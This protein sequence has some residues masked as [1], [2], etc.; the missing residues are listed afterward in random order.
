MMRRRTPGRPD[1]LFLEQLVESAPDAM[2]VVDDAGTV[3]FANR[4]CEV[5]TATPRAQLIGRSVDTLV[6][7]GSR[8]AH[9]AN[10]DR[11]AA[12][13]RTRPMGAGLDLRLR[14]AAGVEVPVDISLSPFQHD[15]RR[16]VA[17]AIRDVT[18][19]EHAEHELRAA[20]VELQ[21]TVEDLRRSTELLLMANEL[22]DL[23]HSC[24]SVGDAYLVLSRFGASFFPGSSGALYRSGADGEEL[25]LARAW[26]DGTAFDRAFAAAECWG[27]RRS[28]IHLCGADGDLRCDH[29]SERCRSACVPLLAQGETLGVLVVCFGPGIDL[30]DDVEGRARSLGEHLSLALANIILRETLRA[31]SIRDPL[32]G[33]YNRRYL[34]EHLH[35]EV[36]RSDRSGSPVG[37]IAIDLDQFKQY[38]DEHGHAAGDSALVSIAAMLRLRSR[39][40]DVVCRQG[41]EE[42]LI[43][44]PGASVEATAERA[45]ELRRAC[46]DLPFGPGR[47]LTISA[48]V[49]CY[50]QQGASIDD[51]LAAVDAALYAA[52]EAGRDRV[53][54]AP[55]I[56]P[57]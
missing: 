22:G 54:V 52:K 40:E 31:Q 29:M 7:S 4:R 8:A 56:D 36:H 32:T 57:T 10:R 21:R 23:L 37:L 35:R 12:D 50:P 14:A 41:G 2:L 55:P 19:R 24:R 18:E 11:Y 17:A 16:F 46:A 34:D 53:A 27:F 42:F 26:G 30:P 13:P 43:V 15:G 1:E 49:G 39:D 47:S 48:G 45:E 20:Q 9:P 33:L 3:V 6:P 51:V 25:E 38:N 5:L 28:R 44:L